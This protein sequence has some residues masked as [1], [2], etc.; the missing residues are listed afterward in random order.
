M[1][2]TRV[3]SLGLEDPLEKE[4]ATSSSGNLFPSCLENNKDRGVWWAAVHEAAKS[5]IRLSN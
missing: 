2:E 4:V 5:R 3:Q 1:Q